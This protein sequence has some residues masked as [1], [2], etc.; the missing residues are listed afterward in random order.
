M[1]FLYR[2]LFYKYTENRFFAILMEAN[3]NRIRKHKTSVKM[4]TPQLTNP[5]SI[6]VIGASADTTKPG[7]KVLENILNGNFK[8]KLYAVNPK[9]T[10]LQ[11]IDCL[12]DAKSLPQTDLAILA[13]PARFCL[14][15]IQ[16]LVNEKGTKGIIVL[17]AG[18]SEMG[19]EGKAMESKM[20]AIATEAGATLIGPNCIGVMNTNHQSVFTT[21]IPNLVAGGCEL[22][23][24]SGATAVFIMESA[25]SKGLPF[26][27]VY[28]VGNAAQT[29]VEEVLAHIDENFNPE[30]SSKTLL[31]YLESIG[32][33]QLFQKYARSLSEKGCKIAAIKSG[34]SDD[35]GRAAA[36]HTGAML[37][38]DTA[39]DALFRKS[40]VVRCY[41]REELST[42]GAVL[43]HPP[44]KG[45]NIAI[46]THAGGPAVML[47][48]ALANGGLSVPPLPE[49]KTS[50][51]LSELFDGSSVAN[52][53]DILATGTASQLQKSIETC[54]KDLDMIDGIAVIFGSP[55]LFPN[56]EAYAVIREQQKKC[57]KP[58][59]AIMP[60]VI[61]CKI[62]M[63]EFVD[64]GGVFF[65]DEV[66]FARALARVYHTQLPEKD[67]H[68]ELPAANEI[69]ELLDGKSGMLD[70][71]LALR[72]LDL[73]GITRPQERLV[74]SESE[75]IEAAREI[76]FPV[77]MKVVGLAHKSEAGGVVL[78]VT[79]E[80]DVKENFAMLMRIDGAQGVQI[81]QMESG[82][83]IL[84]GV[85]KEG[86]FGHL[87]TCGLGGIFVE[88]MKDI[89]SNLAPI[90][91]AE[92]LTMILSL[93]SYPIIRGVRGKQGVDENVIADTLC[94]ISGLLS[95]APQIEE[96]DINPL[97]GR[98]N[99]L[100]AVDVIVKI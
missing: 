33:P 19:A 52:P 59:Y 76:G 81:S 83:E 13:I 35:G 45:K 37:N 87:I 27:S 85:K 2:Y 9:A 31:L 86:D 23:S 97:M 60:S 21:P 55:G 62:E 32:K 96:M 15:T 6:A 58:V 64:N 54:E 67:E 51:L 39:V 78:N 50:G 80:E 65:D 5:R 93:K 99:R 56:H 77:V 48:D 68:E 88:V 95:I 43:Q 61:N 24:G 28:S 98:G 49:D 72:L 82:V 36:S 53:I 73:V 74:N 17:S 79:S 18:F 4:I 14:D 1:A 22:I 66:A 16:T 44:L 12:P 89:Q 47:T 70:T 84:I 100:S 71:S 63:Q 38:S 3:S 8:G 30:T 41:S 75:A 26:S 11:G 57:K 7:G 10:Q 40:G 29:G 92:A 34:T 91:H 46:I 94:K 69:R 20:A 90:S 25:I 42:V